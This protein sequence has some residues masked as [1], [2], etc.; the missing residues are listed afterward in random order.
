MTAKNKNQQDTVTIKNTG[1]LCSVYCP[2]CG[3][4]TDRISFNLLREAGTV[5]V[6]CPSC[7]RITVLEYSGKKITLWHHSEELE[8]MARS[9]LKENKRK[10]KK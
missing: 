7:F 8:E 5:E 1:H 2:N 6:T 9:M 4:V 3:K 10:E